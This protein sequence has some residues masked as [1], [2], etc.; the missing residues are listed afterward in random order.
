MA[1]SASGSSKRAPASKR[2]ARRSFPDPALPPFGANRLCSVATLGASALSPSCGQR[3]SGS[4]S[5]RTATS[6]SRH[7]PCRDHPGS[8]PPELAPTASVPYSFEELPSTDAD[9]LPTR[10]LLD[11]PT[12][13]RATRRRLTADAVVPAAPRRCV[14][15]PPT[16]KLPKATPQ[17]PRATPPV[18]LTRRGARGSRRNRAHR[19]LRATAAHGRPPSSFARAMLGSGSPVLVDIELP[20]VVALEIHMEKPAEFPQ[21]LFHKEHC[22]RGSRSARGKLLNARTQV[23]DLAHLEHTTLVVNSVQ[24]QRKRQVVR[25]IAHTAAVAATQLRARS[26]VTEDR[27]RLRHT[28]CPTTATPCPEQLGPGIR[29]RPKRRS[30]TTEEPW[31]PEEK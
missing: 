13:S 29:G 25:P 17:E 30:P 3:V 20:L 27:M 8:L 22:L 4:G 11:C 2:T 1:T 26:P 19:K 12:A 28:H 23:A 6:H 14:S 31:Q 24:A 21:P 18:A 15:R 9:T 16:A 5:C 7:A 10:Q